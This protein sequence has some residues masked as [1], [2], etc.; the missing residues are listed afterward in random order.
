MNKIDLLIGLIIGFITT[1]LGMFLFFELFSNYSFIEGMKGMK[2]QGFL[3]KIITLGAVL[4]IIVFFI[5]L[6]LDR[7]IMARGVVLAT[8][9]LTILTLFL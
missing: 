6:K 8:I 7:E 5:L 1:T 9:I 3:G 4:N 2:S